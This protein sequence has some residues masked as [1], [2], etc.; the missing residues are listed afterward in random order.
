MRTLLIACCLPLVA[1]CLS[2]GARPEVCRTNRPPLPCPTA[3]VFVA[4][5]SG[6][7]RTVTA[8]LDQVVAES[9]APLRIETV[10]WSHGFGRYLSDHVDHCN[11]VRQGSRLAD[12][13][14]AYRQARPGQKVFLV[15]HSAG[16]A[17]A[18]SAAECLPADSVDR[19]ILLAPSVCVSYDLRP[20]L[21]ATRGGIDVFYSRE[22]TVIL[23]LGMRLVGTAD[24]CC[25]KAAG[26]YGF[27]PVVSGPQD[28]A[29]YGKLRQHPWDPGVAWSGHD[30]GHYGSSQAG[31]L[32]AYVLPLLLAEEK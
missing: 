28:W 26:Q 8:G 7:I 23:G 20:A 16:S 31:F 12:E 22:D 17:V 5:G 2:A 21:R 11:Q 15:G 3:V 19:I 4:N 32:R 29:L 6:D 18:L 30:G 9:G 14:A 10:L 27:T 13:V 25:N 1:G 24:R